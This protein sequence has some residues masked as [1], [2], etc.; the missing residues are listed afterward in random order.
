[1]NIQRAAVLGVVIFLPSCSVGQAVRL[2]ESG[3]LPASRWQ[4]SVTSPPNLEGAVEMVGT[5]WMADGENGNTTQ[6]A[7]QIENAAPGGV[8]PWEIRVG[9]CGV[10]RGV[11]GSSEDYEHLEVGGDGEAAAEATVEQRLPRT[12][13]YSVSILASPTNRELV[14]ACGNLAPPI[15]ARR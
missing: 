6:V 4:A 8:H 3:D 12:G 2:N 10:D 7:I 13:E 9:R 11:F 14:V 5:A 1:M 15:T